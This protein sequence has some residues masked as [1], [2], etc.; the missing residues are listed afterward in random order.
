MP[1][2]EFRWK[3]AGREYVDLDFVGSAQEALRTVIAGEQGRFVTYRLFWVDGAVT[4]SEYAA[5]AMLA[6][7]HLR[8]GSG[9]AA[10]ILVF[11]AEREGRDVAREALE[12]LSPSILRSL[13]ETRDAHP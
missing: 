8:G 1:P 6:W 2:K 7:S 9:D 11:A 5:K 3:E 13:A 12:A 10:L 4:G